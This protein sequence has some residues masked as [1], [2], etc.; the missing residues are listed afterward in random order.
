MDYSRPTAHRMATPSVEQSEGLQPP[1]TGFLQSGPLDAIRPLS[2]RMG[3]T[4]DERA[5]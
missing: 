3:V 1:S 4:L 5:R 2:A